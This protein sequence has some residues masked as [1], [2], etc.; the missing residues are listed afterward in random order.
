MLKLITK[1]ALIATLS[2]CVLP[3]SLKQ[4]PLEQQQTALNKEFYAY[5]SQDQ[6]ILQFD[7]VTPQL[8]QNHI[9][10]I[11]KFVNFYG[12]ADNSAF[13]VVLLQDQLDNVNS[14]V[15]AHT[16]AQAH[17]WQA[18]YD[19]ALG[20]GILPHKV[21]EFDTFNSFTNTEA[22]AMKA[23]LD[24]AQYHP[25]PEDASLAKLAPKIE[26]LER[27]IK[28]ALRVREYQVRAAGCPRQGAWNWSENQYMG[29]GINVGCSIKRNLVAQVKNKASLVQGLP[30][31]AQYSSSLSV[32]A[33]DV[34]S[35]PAD[36]Q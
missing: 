24:T 11:K 20:L 1:L 28:I 18:V 36:G 17:A 21:K 5:H 31:D 3:D 19:E 29:D 22:R 33:I 27:P 2:A 9:D 12:G 8:S 25:I 16:Q 23:I 34:S 4:T 14:S 6:I 26:D 32:E 30:M 35:V 13:F 7:N 10:H 15:P